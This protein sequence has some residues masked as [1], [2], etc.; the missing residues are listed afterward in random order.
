M[1]G[2]EKLLKGFKQENGL[3]TL[4]VLQRTDCSWMKGKQGV[5]QAAQVTEHSRGRK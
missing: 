4:G 5:Q 2:V 3:I 1:D